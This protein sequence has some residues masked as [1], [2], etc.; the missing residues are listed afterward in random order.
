MGNSD[1]IEYTLS[2]CGNTLSVKVVGD[3]LEELRDSGSALDREA[4]ISDAAYEPDYTFATADQFGANLSHAPCFLEELYID[5]ECE[6]SAV[7]NWYYYDA[8]MINDFTEILASG[9]SVDF[10]LA[11]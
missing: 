2:E 10:T 4:I 5:D 1:E 9:E 8:Y 3:L 11:T 6:A 7:G